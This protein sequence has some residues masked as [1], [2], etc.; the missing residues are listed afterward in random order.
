MDELKLILEG[1]DRINKKLEEIL[2]IQKAQKPDIWLAPPKKTHKEITD[3]SKEE[4]HEA[5]QQEQ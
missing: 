4:K 3:G 1:L 2:E 5:Q